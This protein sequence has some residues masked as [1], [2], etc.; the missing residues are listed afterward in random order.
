MTAEETLYT[1]ALT[2]VPGLG[3][4]QALDIYKRV[5]SAQKI[6]EHNNDI[7]ELIPDATPRLCESM[8]KA[9]EAVERAKVELE[10]ANK[11]QIRC[12]CYN[13]EN[14]PQRLKDCDDAPLVLF[15][16]GNAD[17]NQK[18]IVS[19]VGTRQCTQ[20]GKDIL[21]NF[22]ADM[23]YYCPQT[24]IV[25]GLA[26][27]IDVCAHKEAL[28]NGYETVGV[29]AHGFQTLYPPIHRDTAL[30]MLKQGGLVTEYMS[31]LGPD[32]PHFVA[33]NRIV[34]GMSDATIVVESASHGG[35]LITANLAMDYHRD[36]FTFPGN[37][38]AEFSVGCNNL[39]RDNIAS[40]ITNAED[41]IHA[42]KWD[43]ERVKNEIKSQ[44]IERSFFTQFTDEEQII[45]N[46]LL[47]EDNQQLN[48]LAIKSGLPISKITAIMFELEMKGCV[49]LLPGGIYHLYK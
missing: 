49:K 24:L 7:Q 37:V 18:H 44:G 14:Y 5:G 36:V 27:G 31:D 30:A 11:K 47:E 6:F 1:I 2:R 4:I 19:I 39:I 41:F 17:L 48:L 33:R 45:I 10:F 26:Y 25:S 40:L 22:C 12:L 34:A 3:L 13:D 43:D 42:M 23:K 38:N 29:L 21:R 8:R 46:I 35:S 32:K 16:M 15:Y 28:K 9:Q 20:Y